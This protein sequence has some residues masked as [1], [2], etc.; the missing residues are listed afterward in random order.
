MIDFLI[1]IEDII[2]FTCPPSISTYLVFFLCEFFRKFQIFIE[3]FQFLDFIKSFINEK[4]C[5]YYL[6]LLNFVLL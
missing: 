1:S 4:F 5:Y 2:H 6:L 3:L